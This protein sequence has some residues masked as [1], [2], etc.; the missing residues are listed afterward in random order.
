MT[1]RRVILA[2]MGSLPFAR[3]DQHYEPPLGGQQIPGTRAGILRART[4]IIFGT[5]PNVGLFAYSPTP[6]AGHLVASITAGPG[7]DPYGNTYLAGITSYA[8]TFVP[9]PAVQL[10]SGVITWYA[11][12]T[13]SSG[14]V[15]QGSISP[16]SA[17][18][19]VLTPLT[20]SQQVQATGLLVA[21]AGFQTNTG[22]LVG[23][24]GADQ[25]ALSNALAGGL[26]LQV[27]N[28][29]AAP[30]AP[31]VRI[32]GAAAGDAALGIRVSGDTRSRLGVDT[33]GKAQWSDGVNPPDAAVYRAGAN[34]IAAD[35]LA[36]NNAG[37]A[38][39]WQAPTFA[40]SWANS[41]APGV[42]LQYRRNSAPYKTVSWVGRVTAP[43]G[44]VA[45][46]AIITAVPS[47]Y[48]PNGTQKVAADNVTTGGTVR[49]TIGSTGVLTFQAGA[50]AADV[51]DLG[52]L[53]YLDA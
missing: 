37:V 22:V 34:Q 26:L 1:P 3:P 53:V 10:A 49:L 2:A 9:V 27:T 41:G 29:T 33:T 11:A 20:A 19:L 36:F 28:T 13:T 42:N 23:A 4:V 24:S 15:F 17:G 12:P 31:S 18:D 46:Q 8:P 16:D 38:E 43:A 51:I 6:G 25:V 39:T 30:T 21:L 7:T 40:N 5:G 35:Y 47:A 48:R 50:V 45:G 14:Y 52:D 32:V 44:V